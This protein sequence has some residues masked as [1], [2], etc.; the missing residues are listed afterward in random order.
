MLVIKILTLHPQ[1]S[2]TTPQRPTFPDMYL[3][4][5]DLT[6]LKRPISQLA[7]SLISLHALHVRTPPPNTSPDPFHLLYPRNLQVVNR[8][9]GEPGVLF[10]PVT[11]LVALESESGTLA[12]TTTATGRVRVWLRHKAQERVPAAEQFGGGSMQDGVQAQLS[13]RGVTECLPG[14]WLLRWWR[15]ARRHCTVQQ[16]S[17]SATYSPRFIWCAIELH[18]ARGHRFLSHLTSP[19]CKQKPYRPFFESI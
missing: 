12:T 7:L 16:S 5:H 3:K 2:N 10:R 14:W 17:A 18:S 8:V 19:F 1:F 9:L 15:L 6:S 11:V 13:S 4:P